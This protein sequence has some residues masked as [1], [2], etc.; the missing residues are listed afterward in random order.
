MI[1]LISSMFKNKNIVRRSPQS[2]VVLLI[3]KYISDSHY[4]VFKKKELIGE[5]SGQ[6]DTNK[7]SAS[8]TTSQLKGYGVMKQ[9][10]PED[11]LSLV[12]NFTAPA[13]AKALR[14]RE[15]TLHHCAQ[16]VSTKNYDALAK[17]LFPYLKDNIEKVRR[18]KRVLDL[19]GAITRNE[20]IILQRYLHRIPR[21]VFQ[22]VEKRASVI[23]PLCNLN[24]VASV[25]FERRASTMRTYKHQVCFPG[26]MVDEGVD[27]SIIQTCL[28]EMYEELGIPSEKIEVLGV[29]RCDWGEVANFTGIAVTPVVGFIGEM[30]DLKLTPNPTEVDQ[31]F[32]VP[33]KDIMD[34]KNWIVRDF[35]APVFNGG[36][37]VIWGLTAYLLDHFVKEVVLVADDPDGT[38]S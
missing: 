32:T 23:I 30:N 7:P 19:T 5:L 37:F 26:G 31:Y 2:R 11:V 16:L 12:N 6:G 1:L 22:P 29:L 15:D 8:L 38:L 27:S 14:E 35:S 9:N 24:G 21:Q 25:L 34:E 13:L 20:L 28:R 3:S 17:V 18:T 10:E 36:P 33:L 4:H